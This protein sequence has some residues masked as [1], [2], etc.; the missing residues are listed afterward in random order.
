MMYCL[1][2]ST[3]FP[4]GTIDSNCKNDFDGCNSGLKCAV[5]L[6]NDNIVEIARC[7]PSEICGT[8]EDYWS[9]LR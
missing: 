4:P 6:D 3:D 9:E 7:I 8:G 5:L 2:S 1:Q